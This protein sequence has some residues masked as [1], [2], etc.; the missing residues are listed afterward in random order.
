MAGHSK[1]ANIKHRKGRQ[2]AK[3]GKMFTKAT[4]EIMIAAKQ[5]GGDPDMNPRLRLAL[6]QAKAVNLPK[7]KVEQAIKK[8]TG[9]LK[10]ESY[11]ELTYEGYGPGGV[12]LLLDVATDNKNRTVAEIRHILSKHGGS[13]GENGSVSWIFEKKGVLIFDKTHHSEEKLMEVGIEAGAEDVKDEG[14]TYEIHCAPEDFSDVVS[15]FDE[16]GLDYDSAEVTMLPTTTVPLDVE[17]GRKIMRVMDMLEDNEDVQNV[18]A[19]FDIPD[20]VMAELEEA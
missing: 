15:A 5:G 12:A 7:D 2:D 11:E 8:G 6:A 14:E 3:R 1:W 19:N 18:Y 20:E 17:G 13:L 9:E 16:A 4:K 10:G